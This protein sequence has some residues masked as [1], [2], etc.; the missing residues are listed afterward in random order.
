M[1][2]APFTVFAVSFCALVMELAI[3]RLSVFYLDYGSSFLAIPLTLLGLAIGSLHVHLRPETMEK[4]QVRRALF[5]L[6]LTSFLA[7]ALVFLLFSS[8]FSFDRNLITE[9][10]QLLFGKILAFT[11]AFLPPFYVAGRIL[12]ILFTQNRE[13]IGTI[14]GAD[15]FGAALAGFAVPLLF[16]FLDLPYLILFFFTVLAFSMSLYISSYPKNVFTFL[17]IFAFCFLLV[18]GLSFLEG[19]YDLSYLLGKREGKVSELVRGWNEYSRVSLLRLED[20]SGQA[21]GYRIIHDNAESNVVVKPFTGQDDLREHHYLTYIPFV[22]GQP[23]EDVLVMF[24]GCGAQMVEFYQFS[25][26]KARV[27]G[28]EINPLVKVFAEKTPEL[29]NFR[30]A[31]FYA[32]PNVNLFIQEGRQFLIH[33]QDTYDVIYAASD[34]ATAQYK[35]GHSRKYLDTY[36]AAGQY[37]DHLKPGGMLIFQD[38][39]AWPKLH[40]LRRTF[41]DRE[42][43]N[44]D[45]AVII[46]SNY[47]YSPE[48]PW[49]HTLVKPDGFTAEEVAAIRTH[50][51]ERKLLYAPFVADSHPDFL[52]FFAG[53][54]ATSAPVFYNLNATDDRPFYYRLD[55]AGYKPVPSASMLKSGL[56]F[57]SW[58]K[59]Q[60]LLVIMLIPVLIFVL[61]YLFSGKKM[62]PFQVFVYLFLSGFVYMLVQ[63]VFIGKLELFLENPLYSMAL[64]ISIFLLTNAI[65]SRWVEKLQGRVPVRYFPLIAAGVILVSLL[66]AHLCTHFLLGT[67]LILKI[68]MVFLIIS[69]VGISLGFFYPY[70]VI[71]LN[72]LKRVESIP[73]TYGISTLS[74]VMGATYAMTMI[75]NF[76]YTNILLQ[77]VAGYLLL[78]GFL[79]F[80]YRS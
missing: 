75:V 49:Q 60:T 17:L 53:G 20:T 36:E 4:F 62:P 46:L 9:A 69:P 70:A 55:F 51:P 21:T 14:Y 27:D 45:H 33:N 58:M 6:I 23:V 8:V 35:T 25:N 32:L 16:H 19:R 18:K 38:K 26:G 15:M 29:R 52:E 79:Y 24:A 11:L 30:L 12:T 71:W 31:E 1:K 64:L 5:S 59:I 77:A 28:V 13:Q 63:I 42:L 68:L 39:P 2:K 43:K 65:G 78:S 41:E 48:L 22:T 44:F 56:A 37:L 73:V 74:S 76:G 72:R 66:M 34:A 57:A 61:L 40:L 67:P 50:F 80:A 3:S 7:F 54:N 10:P 47:A